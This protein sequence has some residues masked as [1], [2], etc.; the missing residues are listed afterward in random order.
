MATKRISPNAAATM[1]AWGIEV[2]TLAG[3][4][5]LPKTELLDVPFII[6]GVKLT[7]NDKGTEFVWIEGRRIDKTTFTFNDSSSGVR[8]QVLA[9]LTEKGLDVATLDVWI[10]LAVPVL[11]PKGLRVSE[12][13]VDVLNQRNQME[14]KMV[15]TFYLTTSGERA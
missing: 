5:V 3:V 2:E 13:P 9:L 6:T 12:Y 4:D 15:K 14:T 10:D 1:N 7:A 11:V 8:A